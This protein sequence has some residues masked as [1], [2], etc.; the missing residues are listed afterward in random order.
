[1]HVCMHECV[2]VGVLAEVCFDCVL[3]YCIVIGYVLQFGETAP[4]K[5]T[6]LSLIKLQCENR[7]KCR[8]TLTRSGWLRKEEETAQPVQAN[9][10][11]VGLSG[12]S[13]FSLL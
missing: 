9:A 7:F 10:I 5:N 8:N 13:K 2:R 12:K 3:F 4:Y 1:M 11:T 6:L